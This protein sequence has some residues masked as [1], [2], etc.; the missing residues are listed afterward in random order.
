LFH[1]GNPVFALRDI[2]EEII[3]VLGVLGS[4]EMIYSSFTGSGGLRLAERLNVPYHHDTITIP[5]GAVYID[6]GVRYVFHMG[7]K[8]S[9]F[10][11]IE[12]IQTRKGGHVFVPDHSTGTKCGGGSGTLITKQCRRYFENDFPLNLD[13]KDGRELR[14]YLNQRLCS[15]FRRGDDEIETAEK[16]L[17]VGGRCG[18]VIQSD[19]IHLQNSGEKVNNILAGLYL[20]TV[21]NF[22]SDVLK[23][24]IFEP[25]AIA[26]ACG[27]MFE[28]PHFV[29]MARQTL[30]LDLS[31][32]EHF[33]HVG[34]IGAVIK[35][36]IIRHRL[37]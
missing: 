12:N 10:F 4:E 11:E 6:P 26:M 33:R 30:G 29:S 35:S 36:D 16:I 14:H 8:D 27:G 13:N 9:Y 17:D 1:F 19:M 21:K 5:A 7:A 15:I 32:H 24:R 37:N 34:A 2:Y 3:G 28:S 31:V 20:R 23:S 25:G 22:Q 18:V